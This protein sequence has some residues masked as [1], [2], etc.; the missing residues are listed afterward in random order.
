M[1]KDERDGRKWANWAQMVSLQRN[2]LI[3]LMLTEVSFLNCC[4]KTAILDD[5][6]NL[7]IFLGAASGH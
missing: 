3:G 4:S 1:T 2:H 7:K 5:Q 6:K